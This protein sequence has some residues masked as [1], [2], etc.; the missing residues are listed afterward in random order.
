MSVTD[1][2]GLTV[3]PPRSG[4]ALT[5]AAG[6]RLTLVDLQGEQV[7][8]LLCYNRHDVGE[9]L[10]SGRTLDYAETIFLTTGHP[11]YSNRSRVM[12]TITEDEVGRHDFLLTPCSRDTFRIIYGDTDP[13][14]GCFG[15]LAAA[16]APYG[17][18]EDAIP[19]TFNVFMNVAVDGDTGAIRV[20][21]PLSR[22][23]QKLV[24]E[25]EMDL[26]DDLARGLEALQR[27]AEP[28]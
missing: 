4:T 15:N 17:I 21:P 26:L 20:L 23:G 18:G 1:Q 8:D 14:R 5:L 16:L 3:I 19:T 6:E 25:A 24:L 10:S 13:H 11:L 22:A 12:F 2:G 27:H 28:N 9:V 7:A